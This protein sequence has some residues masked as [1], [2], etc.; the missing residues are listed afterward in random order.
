[1]TKGRED[2]LTNTILGKG[3]FG[4]NNNTLS[5]RSTYHT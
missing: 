2:E 3:T 4:I 1:M 5:S